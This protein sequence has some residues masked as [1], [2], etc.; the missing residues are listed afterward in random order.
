MSL[1]LKI[2]PKKLNWQGLTYID[3]H[4]NKLLKDRKII[5]KSVIFA[6]ARQIPKIW[7]NDYYFGMLKG[8]GNF[9]IPNNDIYIHAYLWH[10]IV[11]YYE[12]YYSRKWGVEASINVEKYIKSVMKVIFKIFNSKQNVNDFYE[13]SK[14]FNFNEAKNKSDFDDHTNGSGDATT[15]VWSFIEDPGYPVRVE[16]DNKLKPKDKFSISALKVYIS[17][18]YDPV[19]AEKQSKKFVVK[20]DRIFPEFKKKMS[21]KMKK[22]LKEIKKKK[23]H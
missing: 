12:E 2:D 5:F 20:V 9:L 10:F 13:Q 14:E 4:K 15:D 6:L 1:K 17:K 8:K 3:L 7:A 22:T 21:K 19:D 11:E 16:T 18:K 23:N